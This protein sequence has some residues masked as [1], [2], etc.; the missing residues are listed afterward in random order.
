[1]RSLFNPLVSDAILKIQLSHCPRAETW[2]WYGKKHEKFTIKSVYRAIQESQ[3]RN[4]REGSNSDIFNTLWRKLWQVRV[5]HEV[6]IF[7]WG[8]IKES[9]PTFKNLVQKKN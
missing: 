3:Y 6:K 5:P 9:W 4:R 8:A 2:I 7:A 1:M